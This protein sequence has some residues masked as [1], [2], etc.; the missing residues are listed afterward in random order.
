MDDSL[1]GSAFW[2]ANQEEVY[3]ARSVRVR[4]ENMFHV[5]CVLVLAGS[6][7]KANVMSVCVYVRV[8]G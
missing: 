2:K 8:Y 6:C 1:K 7:T 3:Y 4:F 5:G